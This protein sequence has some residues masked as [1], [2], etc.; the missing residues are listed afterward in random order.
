MSVMVPEN[1]DSD[2]YPITLGQYRIYNVEEIDYNI[3]SF[4][5]SFYL[6]RETIIDSIQSADEVN[7]LIQRD[8]QFQGSAVWEADSIWL[9]AK[10][11]S[12]VKVTENNVP[13]LKLNFPVSLENNWDGNAFNTS[14]A[15]TYYYTELQEPLVD[16]V[17]L[18]DH[19]RVIIE[20]IQSTIVK[21]DERSEVYAKGIGLVEKDYLTLTFCSGSS[22]EEEGAIDGGRL[23]KQTLIEIGNE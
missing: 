2:Y 18:D 17:S 20:D 19:I 10:T 1:D 4:D 16:T 14:S 9:V 12:Y 5:T 23:L 8:K 13:F 22:C 7:Y 11:D 6:L 15:I 3:A 21:Q